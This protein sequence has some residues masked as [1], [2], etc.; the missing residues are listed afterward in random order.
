MDLPALDQIGFGCQELAQGP[1]VKSGVVLQSRMSYCFLLQILDPL[2]LAA[3]LP[4]G[5]GWATASGWVW[6]RIHI[7]A[8]VCS[9]FWLKDSG[10]GLALFE[11]RSCSG[12]AR[13][14][15]L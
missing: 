15:W 12:Y 5:V 3:C 2:T 7:L 1:T 4:G 8:V 10:F 13:N 9:G 11:N 6:Y 14:N